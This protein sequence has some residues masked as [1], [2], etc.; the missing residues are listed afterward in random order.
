MMTLFSLTNMF[1]KDKKE[2]DRVIER[3]QV[4]FVS[5]TRANFSNCD[6]S[7]DTFP[8]ASNKEEISKMSVIIFACPA[9]QQ[10]SVCAMS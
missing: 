5:I 3:R 4:S 10:V 6:L 8:T 9:A 2:R 7:K 1:E